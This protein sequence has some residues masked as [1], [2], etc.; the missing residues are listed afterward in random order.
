MLSACNHPSAVAL[1]S[2]AGFGQVGHSVGRRAGFPVSGEIDSPRVRILLCRATVQNRIENPVDRSQQDALYEE[3]ISLCRPLL[4]RLARAYEADPD[5]RSDLLQEFHIELWRSMASFDHRCSL[6]TWVYRVVH[7]VGATHVIRRRRAAERLVSLET[8]D[9]QLASVDG[10]ALADSSLSAAKLLDLVRQLKPLDR[11]IILLYLEGE[12][13]AQ[14]ADI[15]GLSASNV[16][17]KVH[18]IKRVLSRRFAEGAS[19]GTRR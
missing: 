16:S 1:L 17:T 18:R 2:G 7:N 19:H 10:S 6:R 11:Q 8:L 12:G 14:I 4:W 15:T 5:R 9:A 3:A 13:A